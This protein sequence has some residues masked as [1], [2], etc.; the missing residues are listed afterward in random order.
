M[1]PLAAIGTI[2][3]LYTHTHTV[4]KKKQVMTAEGEK[5]VPLREKAEQREDESQETGSVEGGNE[6]R[7]ETGAGGT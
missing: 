6:S 4:G 5:N 3:P 7:K 1:I 2:D